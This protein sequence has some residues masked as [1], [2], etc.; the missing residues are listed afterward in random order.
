MSNVVILHVLKRKFT[1]VIMFLI[2]KTR[3]NIKHFKPLLL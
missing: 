3:C 2:I 1:N